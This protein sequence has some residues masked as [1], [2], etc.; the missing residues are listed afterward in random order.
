MIT[1]LA[2]DHDIAGVFAACGELCDGRVEVSRAT[3]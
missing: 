3:Q 2:A 1:T